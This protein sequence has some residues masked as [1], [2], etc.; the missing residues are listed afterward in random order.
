MTC[1]VD[2]KMVSCVQF[3]VAPNEPDNRFSRFSPKSRSMKEL[4]INPLI[5]EQSV[6]KFLIEYPSRCLG[7]SYPF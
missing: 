4:F 2:S 6:E 1:D 3:G 5:E 7:T